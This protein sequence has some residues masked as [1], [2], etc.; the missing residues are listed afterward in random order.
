MSHG[1]RT[2]TIGAKTSNN[3]AKRHKPDSPS[4]PESN[5]LPAMRK[6]LDNQ[7]AKIEER[8]STL[9]LNLSEHLKR[10][11]GNIKD[12]QEAATFQGAETETLKA[13]ISHV[14]RKVDEKEVKLQDRIN[15]LETYIAREN[16]LFIGLEEKDNE[17]TEMVVRDFFVHDL[18]LPEERVKDIEFQRLH[19]I[20]S[21]SNPRPIKARFLRYPDATVVLNHARNLKGTKKYVSVDLPKQVREV[22]NM[23]MPAFKAARRAGKLA[24]FSRSDPTKLMVNRIWIPQKDQQRFLN[25]ITTAEQGGSAGEVIRQGAGGLSAT[26]RDEAA[27]DVR[28]QRRRATRNYPRD[29]N[30]SSNRKADDAE[31]FKPAT[32]VVD[33]GIDGA[34]I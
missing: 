23:Q 13:K 9:E 24:Y 20:P 29:S 30:I 1:L 33:S 12:L 11:D 15:Q 2:T 34:G 32:M 16:L 25:E 4:S 21:K 8:F 14:E 3:S 27:D 18:K 10:L 26:D 17:D 22:R 5:L 7:L 31:S 19:R 6:M 28:E